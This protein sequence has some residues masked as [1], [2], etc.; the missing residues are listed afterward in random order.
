MSPCVEGTSEVDTSA[1]IRQSGV[2]A[3]LPGIGKPS[4]HLIY[5]LLIATSRHAA[6][7]FRGET[8]SLL[9]TVC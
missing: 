1:T 4:L 9:L 6:T 8:T 7:P 3:L 5:T 2:S